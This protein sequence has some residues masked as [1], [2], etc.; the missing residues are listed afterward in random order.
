MFAIYTS[1][2]TL[3]HMP[4]CQHNLSVSRQHP[5]TRLAEGQGK[6]TEEIKH[7]FQIS[8][9]VLSVN[10]RQHIFVLLPVFCG[11]CFS[12]SKFSQE[13]KCIYIP[14]CSHLTPLPSYKE[15]SLLS[16][17]TQVQI[18]ALC[19]QS[20]PLQALKRKGSISYTEKFSSLSPVNGWHILPLPPHTCISL[21][22]REAEHPPPQGTF[23]RADLKGWSAGLHL[24]CLY[25]EL[26]SF[27]KHCCSL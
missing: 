13:Q 27:L 10:M 3:H 6:D 5:E 18:L 1:Q 12:S 23:S 4:K 14:F 17:I 16:L 2:C 24:P 8:P 11:M 19:P 22:L 20:I 7:F 15:A 21:L 25:R 26:G 9:Q